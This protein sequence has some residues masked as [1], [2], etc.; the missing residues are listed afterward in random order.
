MK[1]FQNTDGWKNAIIKCKI[2]SKQ[3]RIDNIL[4]YNKDPNRCAYCNIALDYDKRHNTFCSNTCS[5]HNATKGKYHSLETKSK[6]SNSLKNSLLFKT[7]NS[8][9]HPKITI[10]GMCPICKKLFNFLPSQKRIYCSSNCHIRDQKSGNVYCKTAGGGYRVNGGRGKSGKYKGIW[11]NSTY[12]LVWVIYNLD[13]GFMFERNLEPFTYLF[14]NKI[15]RYYPDF[16]QNNE[17]IE[18]KGFMRDCDYEKIKQ[19]PHSL[20]VLFAHNLKMH[21]E[22]VYNTYGKDLVSL[23]DK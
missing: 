12:E 6:I 17:Y 19:F 13:H 16:I 3:K 14:K 7:N 1:Q 21:F 9:A 15:H 22:Y 10:S 23:Y 18:I 20:K 8:I 2:L 5:G 11:C 4:T